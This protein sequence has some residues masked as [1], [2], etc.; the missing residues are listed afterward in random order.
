MAEKIVV[1]ENG[2]QELGQKLKNYRISIAN[3]KSTLVE[4]DRQQVCNN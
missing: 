3:T 2:I 4:D 1:P